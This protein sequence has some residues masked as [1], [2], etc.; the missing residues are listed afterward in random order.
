MEGFTAQ[1]AEDYLVEK[2]G[3]TNE[4]AK[5]YLLENNFKGSEPAKQGFLGPGVLSKLKILDVAGSPARKA[6]I[7]GIDSLFG[8]ELDKGEPGYEDLGG[9]PSFSKFLNRVESLSK[10]SSDEMPGLV[11]MGRIKKGGFFDMSPADV[12]GFG[13]DIVTDPGTYAGI[14]LIKSAGKALSPSIKK[15]SKAIYKIP[16][17]QIDARLVEEGS[18]AVS[19]LLYNFNKSG[20]RKDLSEGLKSIMS[21]ELW[22]KIAEKMDLAKDLKT[23]PKKFEEFLLAGLDTETVGSSVGMKQRPVVAADIQKAK[24]M[25]RNEIGSF[26][27]AGFDKYKDALKK[28]KDNLEIFKKSN[29]YMQPNIKR[30]VAP[31]KPDIGMNAYELLQM[32]KDLDSNISK[33][34]FDE[35]KAGLSDFGDE[36]AGRARNYAKNEVENLVD[37]ASPGSGEQLAELNKQYGTAANARNLM[38]KEVIKDAGRPTF[39]A[40]DYAFASNP[41]TAKMVAVK[42]AIEGM[43]SPRIATATGQ[44]GKSLAEFISK[45]T[46]T[47]ASLPFI[48]KQKSLENEELP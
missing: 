41:H 32:K 48:L 30:P 18:S 8:T 23:D 20:N 13:A 39:S 10:K 15:L 46:T 43:R 47:Q 34:F 24:S 40:M 37:I 26:E 11:K 19:D 16:F 35:S 12:L 6:I 5:A 44:A 36:V 28:Y 4:E 42:E 45:L 3:F 27:P 38:S 31:V 1:E 17:S 7:Q 14:P 2:E 29:S 22:P 25:S 21:D 33:N 9:Y